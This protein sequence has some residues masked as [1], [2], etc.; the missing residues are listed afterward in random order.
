M[1]QAFHTYV[2]QSFTAGVRTY[3][4]DGPTFLHCFK[5]VE[6]NSPTF[7]SA[8]QCK[9]MAPSPVSGTYILNERTARPFHVGMKAFERYV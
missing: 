5:L 8:Q 1:Q 2:N 7:S 4:L 9:K 6:S 3:S